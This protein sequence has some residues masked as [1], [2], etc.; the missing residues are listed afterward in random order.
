MLFLSCQFF[1]P[2]FENLQHARP[3]LS[4]CGDGVLAGSAR[5]IPDIFILSCAGDVSLPSRNVKSIV[6]GFTPL[7]DWR[8]FR[9][10]VNDV[11]ETIRPHVCFQLNETPDHF[12][13]RLSLF[14]LIR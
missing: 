5:H 1:A 6:R 3:W 13:L 7:P 2:S 10:V 12:V 9:A 4:T 14:H 8:R 11:V